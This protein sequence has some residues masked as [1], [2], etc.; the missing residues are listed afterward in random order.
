MAVVRKIPCQVRSVADHGEHVYTVE[1]APSLPV[2]RFQPGQ[3][4][5]LALD[6]YQ[7]GGF[8]PE[9]RVF[10]IASSPKE[11]DRLAITYAVKGVVHDAAWSGSWRGRQRLGQAAVWGVRGRSGPGCGAVRRRD[12]DHGVH[13]IP[14]VARARAGA[15]ACCLFYGARRPDLFVYGHWRRLVPARCPSLTLQPGL[16]GDPRPAEVDA[17]WPAI[18]TLHDPLFYLS[19]PPA[20]LDALTAQLRVRGVSTEDRPHR[21]LGVRSS[22]EDHAHGRQ[23]LHRSQPGRVPCSRSTKSWRQRMQ[24]WT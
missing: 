18:A 24:S 21:C 8:W 19:G 15:R 17:A 10:S 3:F 14:A 23:W 12:R 2:P 1:L 6:A 13:G 4:L 22:D 9:S 20:M 16:R 7:P 5:H 11:R